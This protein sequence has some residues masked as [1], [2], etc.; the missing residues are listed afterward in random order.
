MLF[1]GTYPLKG[2][3][4]TGEVYGNY[5][6]VGKISNTDN[7]V[8]ECPI[9]KEDFELF[10]QGLFS[11]SLSDL[12]RGQ[13]PCGCANR[14]QWTEKQ[15][16]IRAERI[17][18]TRGFKFCG[19]FGP[20]NKNKTYCRFECHIHGEWTSTT[21]GGAFKT[22]SSCPSCYMD[23]VGKSNRISDMDHVVKFYESGSYPI[24]TE[25]TRS[26]KLNSK[27]YKDYWLVYCPVCE[28]INESLTYGL[29][30]GKMPC[31]CSMHSQMESYINLI[32]DTDNVVA[33][34]F[35]IARNSELRVN[36]QN[37]STLFDVANFGVWRYASV[38]DCKGAERE[39]KNILYTS[40]LTKEEF[41]DGYTETT[42]P[43]NLN[44]IIE[45]F[46][47]FGGKLIPLQVMQGQVQVY[48]I[49]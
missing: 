49:Q 43:D 29:S 31:S 3:P 22:E 47:R 2:T 48:L 36:K 6:I 33:I 19:W 12:K 15:Q 34:K 21:V 18:K 1:T 13:I 39:I 27:G 42:H 40:Y 20:Y 45:I 4:R 11:T 37:N 10:D 8:I 7:Y 28:E 23:R 25:F 24:N 44:Q 35:G 46:E 41:P 9:C 14:P 26:D 38:Q 16:L 5:T 30:Q 17:A 32:L